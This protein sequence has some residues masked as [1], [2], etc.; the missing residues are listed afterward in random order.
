MRYSNI[1]SEFT[2]LGK[3]CRNKKIRD[4]ENCTQHTKK[5]CSICLDVIPDYGHKKLINCGHIFCQKCINVWLLEKSS[6]P[7]CRS[8]VHYIDNRRALSWGV[9]KK[10]VTLNTC[11]EYILAY[12]S[13]ADMDVLAAKVLP[14]FV[15]YNQYVNASIY[16]EIMDIVNSNQD[17]AEVFEKVPYFTRTIY[18]KTGDERG[19]VF[20]FKF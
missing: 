20:I 4:S 1:C 14:L 18:S 9:A 19:D 15:Y 6:C 5:T 13:K 7:Y 3:R 8:D 16:S 10:L 11:R 2:L 12:I 17:V